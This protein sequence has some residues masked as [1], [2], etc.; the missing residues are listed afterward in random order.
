MMSAG[1]SLTEI[2][3]IEIPFAVVKGKPV[4]TPPEGLY[5]PPDALE[6]FLE[7]FEGPLDLLLYLIKRQNLDILELPVFQIT[8]QYMKYIELMK[9][10]R[11]EL[12][13]KYLV[14]AAILTEIKSRMMLPKP[15]TEDDEEDPRSELIRRVQGYERIKKA[16]EDINE[17]SSMYRNTFNVSVMQSEYEREKPHP[18]VKLKEILLAFHTVMQRSRAFTSHHIQ[19]EPLSVRECM[20]NILGVL[21][22][23]DLVEF[24]QLFNPQEGRAGFVVTFVA[25]LELIKEHIVELVQ[26]EPFAPVYVKQAAKGSA[27]DG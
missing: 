13:A 18:D 25:L 20:S 7:T 14:M 17:L 22:V 21:H 6:I 23:K 26:S 27:E 12:A 3:Q 1:S 5:I 2:S 8:Q 9:E 10:L 24:K 4:S 15:A 19:R 16:S 11:L